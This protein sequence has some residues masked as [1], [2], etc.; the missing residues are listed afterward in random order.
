MRIT[1][2]QMHRAAERLAEATGKRMATSGTDVGGWIVDYQAGYGG[3]VIYEIV[4]EAGGV[5]LPCQRL[6]V[7]PAQF[8]YACELAENAARMARKATTE[9]MRDGLTWERD[10]SQVSVLRNL[11]DAPTKDYY[12][13]RVDA[14]TKAVSFT[15]SIERGLAH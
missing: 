14:F 1:K 3:V 9:L 10:S 2:A 15:E 5:T 12:T 13:G 4:N 7:P 6:R 8:V 11:R